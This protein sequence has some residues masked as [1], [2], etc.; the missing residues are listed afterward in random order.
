[1]RQVTSYAT[2]RAE[3]GLPA[4]WPHPKTIPTKDGDWTAVCQ[5]DGRLIGYEFK[6]RTER[7]SD[8]TPL[9]TNE[10]PQRLRLRVY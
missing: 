4:K 2:L 7:D 6:N 1:M 10:A 3:L 5:K 9:A 8:D